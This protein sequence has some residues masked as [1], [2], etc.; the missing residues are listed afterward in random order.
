M[1]FRAKRYIQVVISILPLSLSH[2]ELAM[3]PK[4]AE[5]HSVT[6]S[7]A[8]KTLGES[9]CL[10]DSAKLLQRSNFTDSLFA[11]RIRLRE[12][13]KNLVQ[14]LDVIRSQLIKYGV[15]FKTKDEPINILKNNITAVQ[16]GSS[17]IRE[18]YDVAWLYQMQQRETL[19]RIE[20]IDKYLQD[21]ANCH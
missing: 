9:V 6:R 15:G 3:T 19:A 13:S 5:P 21:L 11:E 10:S 14:Q 18:L 17:V 20:Q 7:L 1:S 4:G 12:H 16:F 2:A 8:N